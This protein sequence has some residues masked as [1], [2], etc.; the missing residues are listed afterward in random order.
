MYLCL[1]VQFFLNS[2]HVANTNNSIYNYQ[3][4]NDTFQVG[5]YSEAKM[6]SFQIPCSFYNIIK[7]FQNNEFKIYWPTGTN[8]YTACTITIPDGFY[9]QTAFQKYMESEFIKNSLCL[10]RWKW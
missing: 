7:I 5:K 2:S 8:T 6:T 4:R 3:F 9:N 10:K 1:Y